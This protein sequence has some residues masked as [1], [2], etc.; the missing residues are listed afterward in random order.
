MKRSSSSLILLL[1]LGV[2]SSGAKEKDGAPKP[3]TL[4]SRTAGL[5][6]SDG[7]IPTYWDGKK[8]VLLFE[9][10]A[11]LKDAQFLYFTGF[12]SGVGSIRL[13]ADRSSVATSAALCRFRQVGSRVL[14]IQENPSFRAE[15]GSEALKRSVEKSFPTSVLASLPVEVEEAGTLLV[16]AN[17]LILRDAADLLSQIRA[18]TQAVNGRMIR[19]EG[20]PAAWRLDEARSVVDPDSS[21]SFP[22]NTE[23]E[24]L[25]TFTSEAGSN[26]NQ[27]EAHTLSLSEHHSLV[28]LPEPGFEPREADPRVGFIAQPFQDF[29][30]PFDRPLGRSYIERWRLVKKSRGAQPSEPV[31]PLVF[32]LDPAVPEPIR[33]ALRRGALWWG[34]AFEQAGF[35]SALRIEDLPEGA[36]PMDIRYPTI[37]W[38]N[39]SGRGW[40]VGMTEIDPRTGEIIHAVVQLDSHRM[41]T[42]GNF[43]A[44]MTAPVPTGRGAAD[45]E[46]GFDA[47]A[48]MDRLD[49]VSDVEQ[50]MLNRLALLTCHEM[51]HVLGL[52]HNFIASTF[53]RGSVMDYFAPRVTLRS[54]GTPDLS[55]AYLQGTGSYDRFAIEWGYSEGERGASAPDERRRLDAIVQ[56]GLGQGIVWGSADDPRW[57]AY[58]DGPDPVSWLKEVLPLRA[59]LLKGYGP[60]LLRSGEPVSNLASRFPLIYLFH[61]YALAAAINV[62]GGA[63]VP[64][65]LVGDGQQPVIPWP[66]GSQ[67]EALRLVLRALDPKELDIPPALWKMLAPPEAERPDPERFDSSAGYLFSPHDAARAVSGIV[68]AGLLDPQRLQRVATLARQTPGMP[69]PAEIIG[70]LLRSTFE[71]PG[72]GEGADLAGV[73][74]TDVAERLMLLA[75]DAG[76]RPETQA[77]A[78]AGVREVKRRVAAGQS[79]LWRRLDHEVQLFL[80]DPQRNLPRLNPSTAP[81]GPPIGQTSR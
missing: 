76:A 51:G 29:S 12:G 36:S 57:N 40:S 39:R 43:W 35:K 49:P 18:P 80:A 27:P 38:T 23:I 34:Q 15:Q 44:A 48:A 55:D 14:V 59:A 26:L 71:G 60:D 16:N 10:P 31:K 9:L 4:A 74:Q 73:V 78:L 63:K 46:P 67:R 19:Q 2:L 65:S 7:F 24:A 33:S 17:P 5:K 42:V 13:F 69:T 22:L 1:M 30:Q 56:R 64:P 53:G 50:V 8:G 28:A 61:R 25:L 54:D 3:E 79:P 77:A 37:Q 41:R 72:R 32:Y 62:I 20:S 70:A 68:V 58:D 47:F 21:G 45:A 75:V 81:P 52:E 11:R 6:K 66:A